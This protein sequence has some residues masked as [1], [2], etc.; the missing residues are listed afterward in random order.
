MNNNKQRRE[1]GTG[2]VYMRSNGRWV[3]RIKVGKKADGSCDIKY[4]SGKSESEVKRKIREY[5]KSNSATKDIEKT[6]VGDYIDSWLKTYK[7]GSLKKS[8]YDRLENT[9]NHQIK[10]H[11]GMI[12]LKQLRSEDIQNM[13]F[14][15]KNDGVSYSTIKKAYDCMNAVM[16]HATIAEDIDKDPML[17]VKMPSKAQFE[18]KEIRFFTQEEAKAII[19]ESA[20]TYSTGAPVYIYGEAYVLALNT[21]VRIGELVALERT[22]WDKENKTLHVQRTAQSVKKRDKDGNSN[23][24]ELIFNQTKTYSG[25]IPNSV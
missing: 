8:S 5:N 10:P 23:G 9:V 13:L 16:R 24:Y 25:S 15:L 7:K 18:K 17:L 21:G 4:F 11:I 6:S 19:E 20:R 12:Q 22:D 14:A 3:G 2:N 1:K